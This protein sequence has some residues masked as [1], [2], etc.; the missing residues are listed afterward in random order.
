MNEVPRIAQSRA[1]IRASCCASTVGEQCAHGW[2]LGGVIVVLASGSQ[3][4]EQKVHS[5]SS[6][7]GPCKN[8]AREA[9]LCGEGKAELLLGS[10][11]CTGARGHPGGTDPKAAL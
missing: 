2:G 3:Y 7:V 9:E 10:P 4:G 8:L 6:E 5:N 1:E 11:S